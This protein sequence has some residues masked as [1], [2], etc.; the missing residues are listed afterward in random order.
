MLG[1]SPAQILFLLGIGYLIANVRIFVDGLRFLRRRSR[2]VLTWPGQRP[3]YYGLALAIGVVLGILLFYNVFF[4]YPAPVQVVFGEAMMFIYYSYAVPFSHRIGRGF[5]EDGIWA[6]TGFIPYANIGGITWREGPEAREPTLVI[7]SRLRNLARHLIVP[8]R[9]YAE[10]RRLLR[11][12]IAAH[13]IHFS[14]TGLNLE[15]HD[16][17]EDV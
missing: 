8:G 6:E 4:R 9:H 16:E 17:R 13:D 15:T 1:V 14:G 11:D 10:A 7:I 2:A 3:R 12:K 5:Y